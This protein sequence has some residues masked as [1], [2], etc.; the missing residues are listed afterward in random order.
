MRQALCDAH[1]ALL[2]NTI[3]Y[4]VAQL[5]TAGYTDCPRCPGQF[6]VKL[7]VVTDSED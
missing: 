6:P 5:I 2:Q 4:F 1:H 3:P 7:P